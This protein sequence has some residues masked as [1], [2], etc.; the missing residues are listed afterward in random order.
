[1]SIQ[2]SR[3]AQAAWSQKTLDA[4]T[5]LCCLCIFAISL[6]FIVLFLHIFLFNIPL[7]LPYALCTIIP[8]SDIKPLRKSALWRNGSVENPSANDTN[9]CGK[10]CC[11]S[12]ETTLSNCMSGRPVTYK[13][14]YPSSCQCRTTSTAPA[15][16]LGSLNG[17]E[18]VENKTF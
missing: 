18:R 14:R 1:M 7:L 4:V 17:K 12:H 13:I 10:L 2:A 6:K 15:L 9:P 3:A 8:W 5:L 16:T 11:A